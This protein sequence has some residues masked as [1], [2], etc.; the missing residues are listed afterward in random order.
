MTLTSF[1][2]LFPEF[3]ASTYDTRINTLL[4]MLPEL[5]TDRAG[6]QLELAL[7]NWVAGKL[8][9]QDFAIQY[10]AGASMGSSNS[11]QKTVGA[12]SI[13]RSTSQNSSSTTSNGKGGGTRINLYE[14]EYDRL[15][16]EFG[17]GA[18]AVASS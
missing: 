12:V 2:D 8:A 13:T 17:M 1:K 18:V 6:N 10:G 14:A 7:G 15:L 16:R 3:A 9:R 11:V 4:T 5:D